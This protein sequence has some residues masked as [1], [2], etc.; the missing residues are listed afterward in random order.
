MSGS[1]VTLVKANILRD[2]CKR[3]SV[4]TISKLLSAR[5]ISP[6]C[7]SNNINNPSCLCFSNEGNNSWRSVTDQQPNSVVVIV[8]QAGHSR[9][10]QTPLSV[11]KYFNSHSKFIACP[12]AHEHCLSSL[13]TVLPRN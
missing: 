2:H 6:D 10:K 1:P 5:T 9:Y 7:K 12:E 13:P 4:S 11:D 8:I 3:L